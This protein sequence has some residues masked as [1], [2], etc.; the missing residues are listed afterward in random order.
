MTR[1]IEE[2]LRQH[3]ISHIIL[4]PTRDK[5]L[6][7]GTWHPT[8]MLATCCKRFEA[9]LISPTVKGVTRQAAL[10]A[11]ERLLESEN[12]VL[13]YPAAKNL[14]KE[15]VTGVL[16]LDDVLTTGGSATRCRNLFTPNFTQPHWHIL[17]IFRSPMNEK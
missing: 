13:L 15:V 17:T 3:E 16:F 12:P 11:Q 6:E 8:H 9:R 5:R 10:S 1:R 7:N 2:L 14:L 4:S